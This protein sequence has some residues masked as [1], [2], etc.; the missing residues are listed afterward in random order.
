MVIYIHSVAVEDQDYL[1]QDSDD[2][3]FFVDNGVVGV[4]V[5]EVIRIKAESIDKI[6]IYA[7]VLKIQMDEQILN[8][9]TKVC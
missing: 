8:I 6:I 5:V 1:L 9:K 3:V 4:K 7:V 2:H